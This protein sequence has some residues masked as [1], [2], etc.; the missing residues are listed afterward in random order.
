MT[1][2]GTWCDILRCAFLI[3]DI[4]CAFCNAFF[5]SDGYDLVRI[6][7]YFVVLFEWEHHYCSGWQRYP[8][9][10]FNWGSGHPATKYQRKT[11]LAYCCSRT[12][13]LWTTYRLCQVSYTFLKIEPQVRG[14]SGERFLYSDIAAYCEKLPL[15]ITSQYG[16]TIIPVLF[17]HVT[18]ET[19]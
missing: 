17:G 1:T 6:I 9:S 3:R 18:G 7:T 11:W 13:E 5:I 8:A 16:N 10:L 2:E 12:C 4:W 19:D 14:D 15:Y